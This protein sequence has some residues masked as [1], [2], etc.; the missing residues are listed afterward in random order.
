MPAD[1][2]GPLSGRLGRLAKAPD[3]VVEDA[4][5]ER[6]GVCKDKA[7]YSSEVADFTTSM[8][9]PVPTPYVSPR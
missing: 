5:M 9:R 2:K 3:N 6:W 8:V 4:R 7:A 1:A